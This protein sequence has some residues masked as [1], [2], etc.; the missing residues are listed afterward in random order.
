MRSFWEKC[1]TETTKEMTWTTSRSENNTKRDELCQ[2]RR[3]TQLC[4]EETMTNC[5]NC[6]VKPKR[7]FRK[8][9]TGG[10]AQFEFFWTILIIF[11]IWAGCWKKI[12]KNSNFSFADLEKKIKT[13]QISVF[14]M[15]SKKF[16]TT[17]IWVLFCLIFFDFFWFFFLITCFCDPV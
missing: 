15:C 2:R 5:R 1:F 6:Y 7:D 3:K 9:R 10:M 11:Q 14:R 13:I 8:Y 12:Q 4:S 17:Q 16:K